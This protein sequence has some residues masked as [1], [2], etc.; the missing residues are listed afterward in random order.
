[1]LLLLLLLLV[2]LLLF[3][4][5]LLILVAPQSLEWDEGRTPYG[6]AS[7]A[8]ENLH[9]THKKDKFKIAKVNCVNMAYANALRKAGIN[10]ATIFTAHQA[11]GQAE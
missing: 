1:M 8:S 10:P 7:T 6:V 9:T 5:L 11:V 2:L 3:L 4:L